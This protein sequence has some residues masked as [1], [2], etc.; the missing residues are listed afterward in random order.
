MLAFR[1][2][3]R[4]YSQRLHAS[5][6][7]GRWNSK[8][9]KV[10]YAAST[11]ELAFLESMI[12]RKG[13]GFNDDFRTMIIEIP[14]TLKITTARVSS[15]P[16]NWRNAADYSK[17]QAIGDAWYDKKETAIL[18]V[19]SALIPESYNYVINAEHEL[20]PR[21]KLVGVTDLIPDSRVEEILKKYGR[22]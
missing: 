8:G 14:P 4:K 18:K 1:I 22:S 9:R 19:P 10:I 16:R 2:A 12:R 7:E 20:F 11:L 3:H 15:L 6:L 17:C 21:I 13:I 5:G